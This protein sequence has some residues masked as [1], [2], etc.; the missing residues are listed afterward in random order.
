MD[1]LSRTVFRM[2]VDLDARMVQCMND[3]MRL[4]PDSTEHRQ[5]MK[6]IARLRLRSDVRR[7]IF[8]RR[9]KPAA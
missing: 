3:A 9:R 1:K 2:R 8:L 7:W 4:H 6:E 5:I